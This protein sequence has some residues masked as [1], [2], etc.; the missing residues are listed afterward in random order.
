[1]LKKNIDEIKSTEEAR[2]LAI[3]WQQ[4]ASEQNMFWSE[5][6]EWQAYFETLAKEF[7]LTEEFK[8]NGVI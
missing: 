5:V 4:W 2:T 1:M 8:E 3:L 7:N 6:S